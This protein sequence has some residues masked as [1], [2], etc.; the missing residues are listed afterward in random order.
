[1]HDT[2][3]MAGTVAWLAKQAAEA[4]RLVRAPKGPGECGAGFDLVCEDRRGEDE[5][6][7]SPVS[8]PLMPLPRGPSRAL[9]LPLTDLEAAGWRVLGLPSMRMLG[10]GRVELWWE[11]R[12]WV[13]L[14]P[15]GCAHAA[16]M[17]ASRGRGQAWASECFRAAKA[18]DTF[19]GDR[20]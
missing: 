5:R 6:G 7:A 17:F 19:S 11:G 1:M 12:R 10:T 18:G 3:R 2:D 8:P 16:Q 20:A 13:V 9:S 14:P 15:D 4:M